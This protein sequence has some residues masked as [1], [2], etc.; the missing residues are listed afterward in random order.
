M[1]VTGSVR[2]GQEIAAAAAADLKRLHLELGGNAPVLIHEDADLDEAVEQLS[3]LA[4]YNA[5]QD[6][7]AATRILVHHRIHDAFLDAFAD[8][9]ARLR[10]GAFDDADADF[11]PLANA[12]QLATVRGLLERLPGHTEVVTGGMALD[13]PGYFHQ[14]TVV[15]G[16]R[17]G[18][19][20]VRSEVFG[21]VVT[22]QPFTDESEAFEMA[23]SVPQGLAASVWTRDHDRAMRAS[24]ALHTG[25]VWVNTHGTTVSE[26]PHGGVR[27]SGYG[28]DLSLTG[29]LDYTQVKHVM[30]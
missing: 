3:S 11:G 19:E 17:Q 12:G 13:R 16:A 18:D 5:G 15:A 4:F 24:R 21:P 14:T 1:A 29:L 7:T 20:I 6:C 8:R 28:S 2:A 9:A 30:L 25:I 10:P 22:V 27:H 26:M 23:N